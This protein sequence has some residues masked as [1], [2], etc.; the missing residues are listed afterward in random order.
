MM[1]RRRLLLLASFGV[2]APA[3]AQARPRVGQVAAAVGQA[4]AQFGPTPARP[5]APPDPVLML[6]TL[7]T[8]PAA[9]L[10]CTLA[11]GIALRLGAEALLTIDE[12]VLGRPRAG[13]VL[14]A[15][16]GPLLIE[17][18]PA[19]AQPPLS[20]TLPWARI[21]VRGTRFFAGPLDG[22][23]AVFVARGRVAVEAGTGIVT[24][25]AGEGVDI[26]P[27]G[28]GAPGPVR[29]WGDARI[30]RAMAAVT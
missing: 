28:G 3:F 24:L 22:V 7:S 23:N 27:G 9:R 4:T 20:V 2:A 17:R 14:R 19:R 25:E 12:A 29:R 13:L 8:G 30:A 21:G 16:G 26:P 1:T 18:E 11:G 6:D 15:Q 5:L 10:A